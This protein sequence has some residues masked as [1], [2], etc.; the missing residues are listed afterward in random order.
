MSTVE[1]YAAT[2][3]LAVIVF[4]YV[5][6]GIISRLFFSANASAFLNTRFTT[7]GFIADKRP[8]AEFVR[9]RT[10]ERY[11]ATVAHVISVCVDMPEGFAHLSRLSCAA[12][13]MT[14]L[15]FTF[16]ASRFAIS[17]PLAVRMYVRGYEYKGRECLHRKGRFVAIDVDD[18][19]IGFAVVDVEYLIV[20]DEEPVFILHRDDHGYGSA[21]RDLFAVVVDNFDVCGIDGGAVCDVIHAFDSGQCRRIRLVVQQCGLPGAA[22]ALESRHLYGERKLIQGFVRHVDL[23]VVNVGVARR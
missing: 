13:A 14:N 15:D 11:A 8:L 20:V 23:A 16:G 19:L 9:M 17:S 22:D 4:V 10:V 2:V 7:T 18:K 12:N 5:I 1:R 6:D 3:A 21:H